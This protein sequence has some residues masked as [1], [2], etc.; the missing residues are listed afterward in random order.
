MSSFS[1][2]NA[3]AG[4]EIRVALRFLLPDRD[5]PTVLRGLDAL[6]IPIR[7]FHEANGETRAA[8]ARPVDQVAQIALGVAQVGLDD[9]PG[10]RPIV[11]F[12][13]GEERFEKIERGIFV[14]V[15]L[16]VEVDE[17]AE[18]FRAAQNRAQLRREMRDGVLRIGRIHL[19]IE[20]GDFYRQIDDRKKL[21]VF[22]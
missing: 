10:V 9:D 21:G 5:A 17:R 20:R 4:F 12:R 22:A 15:T 7:A 11:E 8:L 6:V 1:E 19:R 2:Q 14:R 13:F 16:H 3:R 18:F